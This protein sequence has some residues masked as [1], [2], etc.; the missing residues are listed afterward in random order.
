[1]DEMK[2]CFLTGLLL[3]SSLLLGGTGV[4]HAE[5]YDLNDNKV[6]DGWTLNN[7]RSGGTFE[8]GALWSNIIDSGA[9]I[10]KDVSKESITNLNLGWDGS[11]AYSYWGNYTGV[12]LSM[13]D[14][15][16]YDF[17]NV[18]TDHYEGQSLGGANYLEVRAQGTS[19]F[20]YR[21][22][23]ENAITS[24]H[25]DIVIDNNGL[26]TYNI[27]RTSDN[28][29]V[30]SGTRN[31]SLDGF[32]LSDI[33][34]VGFITYSTTENTVSIDNLKYEAT[35]VSAPTPT[36]TP[37]TLQLAQ[38]SNLAYGNVGTTPVGYESVGLPID[39]CSVSGYCAK[40]YRSSSGDKIV[41]SFAG[42]DPSTR[43]DVLAD[44]SFL[45]SKFTAT[46]VMV[47]YVSKA[48]QDFIYLKQIYPNS[49]LVLTGHSLGGAIAQLIAYASDA[50]V[51]T[52]DAPGTSEIADTSEIRS[53]LAQLTLYS[54]TPTVWEL[55]NVNY[56]LYDDLI[57]TVGTQFSDTATVTFTNDKLNKDTVNNTNAISMA[58]SAHDLNN[59][60]NLLA[61]GEPNASSGIGPDADLIIP[62]Y[63]MR[64]GE[65][66]VVMEMLLND[67]LGPVFKH[68]HVKSL[69]EIVFEN[70]IFYIDP[71]DDDA[72]WLSG[73]TGS[74]NFRSVILPYLYNTDAVF[75]LE[76]FRDGIWSSLGFFGELESYDFGPGG[77]DQFRFFVLDLTS[78]LPA[79]FVEEF[80]IGVSFASGGQYDGNLASWQ[81]QNAT[82]T[83]EPATMLLFGTGIAGLAA[84]GRRKRS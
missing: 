83:P 59:M 24:Y 70:Q 60:I 38:F 72:Y 50:K 80:V 69:S 8:N 40:A 47:D 36:R 23:Y 43:S 42:T 63:F 4:T 30:L 6:P 64:N 25:N 55:R 79:K 21:D 78:R 17:W 39:S 61:S 9:L 67:T 35:L 68:V 12:T 11:K 7:I 37:T 41:L 75:N 76:W 16:Q 58:L 19:N 13:K 14:N 22:P 56:R 52:F 31:L 71:K 2:K 51:F 20:T 84:V 15:T 3:A 18:Y 46:P 49:E 73:K 28:T 1:M 81:T 54:Q 74:P 65:T 66:L 33:S 82:P 48:V 26:L 34:K 44:L 57:S 27:T 45:N 10:E 53:K 29:N 5:L 62:K 77:V 32:S